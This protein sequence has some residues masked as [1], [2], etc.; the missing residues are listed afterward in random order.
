MPDL[1]YSKISITAKM[2]AYYRQFSDIPFAADVSDFIGAKEALEEL[3]KKLAFENCEQKEIF[4]EESKIY[5]PILEMRYKSVIGLIQ[6]SGINQILELASCFSLRGLA[7][8]KNENISY[9]ETDLPGINAE[10][11][12]L[13]SVLQKKYKFGNF[14]NH[15]VISANALDL[16]QLEQ[17]TTVLNRKKPIAIV[18]EG[19]IPYLSA[20]E[21]SSLAQ[22]IR[23]VID[24]FA[25]KTG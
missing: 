10:K 12:R 8:A 13:I 1:D 14:D 18:N 9:V 4:A 22:N 11:V 3:T 7:M 24:Q 6:K 15:H 23:Y 20:D 2:V 5:A 16:S 21:L 19:L 17:A 25:G